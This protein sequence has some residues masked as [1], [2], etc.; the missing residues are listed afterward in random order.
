[1]SD[2]IETKFKRR[3]GNRI[4]TYPIT[5][6]EV[7][8]RIEFLQSPFIMKDEIK[9][10]RGSHWHGYD[11]DD[12]RKIWSI[13]DCQ[14][15]RFQMEVLKGTNPYQ[16]FDR[17]LTIHDY[18]RPLKNH[19]K[20]LADAGLTYHYQIFGAAT[21]TGKTLSAIEVIER[22]GVKKWWWVAPKS[23]L[24]AVEPEFKTWELASDIE[25]ELM[26]YEGMIKRM[27]LWQEGCKAP[28]GVVFDESQ[29]LKNG[30]SQRAQAAQALADGVRTDWGMEGFALLLSGTP[31]P[32]S[33]VDWYSQAE[34]AWPGFLREGD[35]DQFRWRL[36]IF[37]DKETP[38]GDTFKELV[39]WKDSEDRCAVCGHMR[40]EKV[41]DV[42]EHEFTSCKNEIAYL[43]ER[44]KGLVVIYHKDCLDLPDK[45]YRYIK[46]EPSP[47]T[48]R[49]A[50]AAVKMAPNVVTGTT[51][52][53]EIS[54][55]F[56]YQNTPSGKTKCT[57][58]GGSGTQKYWVDPQD[59]DR[60]FTMPDMLNP[61]YVATLQQEEKPCWT[62]RGKGEIEK[63]ERV[64][65]EIP[66]PKDDVIID[67]LEENDDVGRILIF[68]AFTGSIDRITQICL[69][70]GWDVVRVDGRGWEVFSKN[71]YRGNPVEYWKDMKNQR[72]AFVAHPQSGGLSLT[73]TEAWMAVFYIFDYRP[74]SY[75]QA[76]DRIHRLG[77]DLN[78]G[79]VIVHIFH[80]ESDKKIFKVIQSNRRIEM[81]TMGNFEKI[82]EPDDE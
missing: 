57:E 72:V 80:L 48:I 50:Q 21:G 33:P 81:M 63:Y 32:K 58:C 56:I 55:G 31:A 67:L 73:L 68:A 1:M 53:R 13:E 66:C 43:Y 76:Q 19:Q 18:I 2:I 4:F 82:L 75:L 42:L 23:G 16:W 34:I 47:S 60:V 71:R 49:A 54:D 6:Q 8:G 12:K 37:E 24:Y 41:C 64:V 52:L 3:E 51:W 45:N 78:K 11:E 38:L 22:S 65:R 27:N 79:A 46:C 20:H 17:P 70:Q 77:M 5:L 25:I 7:D 28:P 26:T 14:R 36:G 29:R 61:E 62:C 74:E 15:N 9:A 69:K 39:A 10:M 35:V 59:T 30:K 44:L 40:D